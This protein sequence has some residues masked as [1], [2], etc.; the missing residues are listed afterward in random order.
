MAHGSRRKGVFFEDKGISI[1]GDD[2]HLESVQHRPP[3][4]QGAQVQNSKA[5]QAGAAQAPARLKTNCFKLTMLPNG[6]IYQLAYQLKPA[7]TSVREE[8]WVLEKIWEQLQKRLGC[9]FVVHF[10]GGYLFTPKPLDAEFSLE[11][12]ADAERGYPQRTVSVKQEKVFQP[13][14]I[15]HGNCGPAQVVLQHVA[16][17][18]ADGLMYQKV[19]RRYYNNDD[20]TE[21]KEGHPRSISVFVGF[22]M[23]VQI[24]KVG[25]HLVVNA[26]H[27]SWQNQSVMETIRSAL[28]Q[29]ELPAQDRL[30][31]EEWRRRCR[32]ATV[33]TM[34]NKRLYRIKGVRFDKKVTD[35][36]RM[37][38]RDEKAHKDMTYEA[39]YQYFYDKDIEDKDQ[40]LLE[41]YP[42]KETETVLLVPELC[43][44]TGTSPELRVNLTKEE[45]GKTLDAIRV[46]PSDRL[47]A[48]REIVQNMSR[49]G[50]SAPKVPTGQEP[51]AP[52]LTEW[53]MSL[54]TQPVEVPAQVFPTLE[55][56]F[57]NKQFEVEAEGTFQRFMRNG[58]QA[59]TRLTNWILIYPEA[60]YPVLEIWIRSLKDIA[61]VAF[62]M[63]LEFPQKHACTDQ[64]NDIVPLLNRTVVPETQLVLLLCPVETVSQVYRLIKAETATR[65]P[66]VTQIVKSDTI[67]KR[68]QIA[69]VLSAIALQI[70]AKCCGP[71]WQVQV[72]TE[73]TKP[74]FESATMVVGIDVYT[75]LDGTKW[76]GFAASLDTHC[77]EYYSWASELKL[78]ESQASQEG[79]TSFRTIISMK[80][81]QAMAQALHRFATRNEQV[82]PSFIIVYRSSVRLSEEEAVRATEVEAVL[83]VL[84]ATSAMSKRGSGTAYEPRL[85]FVAITNS[86]AMRF[87]TNANGANA[88]ASAESRSSKQ[89]NP[90]PG[91]VVDSPVVSR[92]SALN[93][94]LINQSASKEKGTVAPTHY[95]VWYDTANVPVTSLQNLTYRLSFLYYNIW[96]SIR[97]PAPAQYA[98]KVARHIG[99]Y[100]KAEPNDRLRTGFFYL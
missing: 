52:V 76:L 54:D 46:K 19:G 6:A 14:M 41:A 74:Y 83:T 25:A 47:S 68:T 37:Y 90:E 81:Q 42:E 96:M 45:Y 28:P 12:P 50:V 35:N 9:T 21:G 99:K 51:S 58:V 13:D 8:R 92:S 94:W 3:H 29:P 40:P 67:R 2:A 75:S 100:V 27:R 98:K 44:L 78:D 30:E 49:G 64:V 26:A 48:I 72:K 86:E 53:N 56:D 36:F 95:A 10:P 65:L 97:L 84:K 5:R 57:G 66:V 23:E 63:K 17:K 85:T 79:T 89:E 20:A 93:F 1:T 77:T 38:V 34:Y 39:Y 88:G 22:E 7:A 24:G 62:E 32:G 4:M 87:F 70:N 31:R 60:D 15:N 91:T 73:L 59:S 43:A 55:V 11:A 16:K 33:V 61:E 80:L 71:L 69:A 18:L 82:L